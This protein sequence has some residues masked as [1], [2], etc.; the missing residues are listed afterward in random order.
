MAFLADLGLFE[1]SSRFVILLHI[2]SPKVKNWKYF[3]QF[4]GQF[5]E[6]S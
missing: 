5:E 1:K 3:R 2:V 6:L 4:W